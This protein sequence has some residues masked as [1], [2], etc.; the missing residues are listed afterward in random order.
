VTGEERRLVD[1]T[2]ESTTQVETLDP[3][4]PSSGLRV[5]EVVT[6][7]SKP[8]GNGRISVER[9]IKRRDTNG[10]LTVSQKVAQS[11]ESGK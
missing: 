10:N 6:E 5:S 2:I 9:V 8:L 4:N 11:I 3:A 7:T 1:G